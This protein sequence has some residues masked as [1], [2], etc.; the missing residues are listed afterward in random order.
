MIDLKFLPLNKLAAEHF[1]EL[2]KDTLAKLLQVEAY[3][4]V[5]NT[6]AGKGGFPKSKIAAAVGG[7]R[8]NSTR[9]LLTPTK[10]QF[11]TVG[12]YSDCIAILT[13]LKNNFN[14]TLI[15]TPQE[16]DRLVNLVVNDFKKHR[17][18]KKKKFTYNLYFKHFI[19]ALKYIWDYSDFID[20]QPNPLK[21]NAYRLAKKLGV[22]TCP[23]C[24]RSY[25][26]TVSI[27]YLQG[28]KSKVKEVARPEF[29]H[30]YSKGRYPFL[31]I[32]FYNLVPSCSLCNSTLKGEKQMSITTH[33]HPY[34]EGYEQVFNFTTGITVKAFLNQRHPNIPIA[35]KENPKADSGHVKRAIATHTLFCIEK[36]YPYHADIAEELFRRSTEDSKKLIES[37]WNQVSS[38]GNYLFPTKDDLYRHFLGNYYSTKDF[39]KRPLAKFYYDILKETKI[40]NYIRSLPSRPLPIASVPLAQI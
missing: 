5:L 34:V 8:Q 14:T 31:G 16:I 27:D 1:N 4:N 13:T 38:Q 25:T 3:F 37:Y 40:V 36:I 32:G 11:N 24:N 10:N 29:D 12:L 22:N 7:F 21:Y 18:V 20:K 33:C 6:L 15:G 39:I 35:F 30:F 28:K 2:N 17:S 19:E 9:K 26:F 23:Y